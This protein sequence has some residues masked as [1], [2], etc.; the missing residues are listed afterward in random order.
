[1]KN[2]FTVRNMPFIAILLA[3]EIVLQFIGN[4]VAF[5][6]V[7]INLSLVPIALGAMLFGPW[8]GLFLGIINS[9]FVLMAPST[10]LFYN[11]SAGGTIIVCLL[12]SS[13]AGFLGGL[14]YLLL[15]NKN[16]FV[17]SIVASITLPVINTGIFILGCLLFFRPLLE[18]YSTGYTSIYEFL[19][20]GLIGWNFIF[21]LATSI[22][23][24]YPIYRIITIKERHK[25]LA[26]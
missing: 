26:N 1:M 6:P 14:F 22:V 5:G 9:I 13:L 23:L 16:G 7:S 8:V 24:V 3:I 2:P 15:K 17:A 21:E 25:Q 19:F 4:M 11:V 10:A 20:I 18:E 12:K